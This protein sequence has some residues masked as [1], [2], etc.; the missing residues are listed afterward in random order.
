MLVPRFTLRTGLAWLTLGVFVAVV[1]REALLE[2][3]W[4]IGVVVAL[5][6]VVLSLT[7]QACSFGMSLILSRGG[8]ETPR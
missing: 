3:A 7:L 4:A 2:K 5:G 8:E 6:A 1:I